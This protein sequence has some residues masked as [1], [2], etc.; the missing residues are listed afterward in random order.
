MQVDKWSAGCQ[1]TADHL[2][3]N[4]VVALAK[5]AAALYGN[6]FSYTLL[7]EEQLS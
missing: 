1:V 5:K 4:I 3:L 2:D 6:S 7:S